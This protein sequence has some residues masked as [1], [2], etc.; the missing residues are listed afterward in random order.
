MDFSLKKNENRLDI[1]QNFTLFTIIYNK[2]LNLLCYTYI[3][4][5]FSFN[6]IKRKWRIIFL[7]P[8]LI[9]KTINKEIPPSFLDLEVSTKLKESQG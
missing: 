7:L 2:L 8:F 3:I 5:N 1:H 6:S 9:G 4:K